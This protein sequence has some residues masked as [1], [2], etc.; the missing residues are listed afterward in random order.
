MKS[1]AVCNITY[2]EPAMIVVEEQF[3]LQHHILSASINCSQSA[4]PFAT[5][6]TKSQQKKRTRISLE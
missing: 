2:K 5:S 6:H 3:H 1:N 4:I